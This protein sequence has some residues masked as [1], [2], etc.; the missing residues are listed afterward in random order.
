MYIFIFL[1][2]PS[3]PLLVPSQ[4]TLLDFPS[5]IARTAHH[6]AAS[7][8]L[9]PQKKQKKTKDIFIEKQTRCMSAHMIHQ[10]NP[11]P[12]SSQM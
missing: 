4:P 5:F 7:P 3:H 11:T 2:F 8:H 1:L 10:P 12:R 9:P 6:D